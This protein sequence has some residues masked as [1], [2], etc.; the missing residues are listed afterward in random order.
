MS[1]REIIEESMI[2]NDINF[3]E[4]KSSIEKTF[5]KHFP[6][7]LIDIIERKSLGGDN[8]HFIV[9]MGLIGNVRDNTSGIAENDPMRHTAFIYPNSDGKS[10]SFQGEGKIYTKPAP[11]SY[12]AMDSVRTKF[13]NKSK[14]TLK[15][16]AEHINKFIPRLASL[17]KENIEKI[18]G[19]EKVDKKYSKIN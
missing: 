8:N 13:G 17:A 14:I 16:S 15:K 9:Y 7:G 2:E 6:N 19:I 1:F 4:F 18:Y 5:K 11:D 3:D 10:Y 12:Y